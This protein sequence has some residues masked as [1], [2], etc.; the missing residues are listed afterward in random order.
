MERLCS[1][2]SDQMKRIYT[3]LELL[4][5]QRHSKV[6]PVKAFK[7]KQVAYYERQAVLADTSEWSDFPGGSY[8]GGKDL[9]C[10]FQAEIVLSKDL[11]E[12]LQP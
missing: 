5:Q 3:A 12:R 10:C 11:R 8:W 6:T 7:M 9:H 1:Q 4:K 2:I